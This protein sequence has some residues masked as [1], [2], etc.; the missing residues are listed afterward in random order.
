MAKQ[1][2]G[3]QGSGEIVVKSL[4]DFLAIEHE[5]NTVAGWQLGND[6]KQNKYL[7]NCLVIFVVL[8]CIILE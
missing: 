2:K 7:K 6:N 3:V 4:R 1:G 5:R 8:L